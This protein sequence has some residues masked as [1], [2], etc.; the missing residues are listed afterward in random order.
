MS[1][2]YE[3]H[4]ERVR[5]CFA[6]VF[7]KARTDPLEKRDRRRTEAD[8]AEQFSSPCRDHGVPWKHRECQT[9]LT[10]VHRHHERKQVDAQLQTSDVASHTSVVEPEQSAVTQQRSTSALAAKARFLLGKHRSHL[11]RFREMRCHVEMQ[12]V[13][14]RFEL[15]FHATAQS[16]LD[17]FWSSSVIQTQLSKK[18]KFFAEAFFHAKI[19]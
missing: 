18:R 8:D 19:A 9:K 16:S 10:R 5:T 11:T 1:T 7:G 14:M 15:K 12:C 17:D 4:A 3:C 6:K 13:E 2:T